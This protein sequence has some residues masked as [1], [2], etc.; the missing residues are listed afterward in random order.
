MFTLTHF[1]DIFESVPLVY[2]LTDSQPILWLLRHKDNSVKLMRYALKLFEYSI[3]LVCVH[4]AGEKNKVAD[5]LS[6]LVYV[7]DKKNKSDLM[8]TDAQHIEPT[9]HP[10]KIVSLDDVKKAFNPDTVQPC[11]EKEPEKCPLNVNSQLYRGLGPYEFTGTPIDQAIVKKV[12]RKM[13]D[14]GFSQNALNKYLTDENIYKEQ[15]KDNPLQCL[16]RHIEKVPDHPFLYIKNDLVGRRFKTNTPDNIYIPESLVPY[17]LAYY[18]LQG[19]SGAKK[20]YNSI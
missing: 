11:K 14:F 3:N 13:T 8:P 2:V 15:I 7:T 20:L 5:F 1:R 9:F 18:H 17:V 16:R 19:H 4:I 6:R 10:L 12:T